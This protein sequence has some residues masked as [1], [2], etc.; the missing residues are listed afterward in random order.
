[1]LLKF[2]SSIQHSVCTT[3]L[4][5]F[6]AHRFL[7]TQLTSTKY[8]GSVNNECFN[9]DE[10]RIFNTL[11]KRGRDDGRQLL[12]NLFGCW[13]RLACPCKHAADKEKHYNAFSKTLINVQHHTG[14]T[15]YS[16]HKTPSLQVM[17]HTSI[18]VPFVSTAQPHT[19]IR[20]SA[21]SEQMGLVGC[22]PP[23]QLDKLAQ[24]SSP[25]VSSRIVYAIQ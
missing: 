18:T 23:P 2:I 4:T 10:P 15:Q 21:V 7:F 8:N 25:L 14:K 17:N 6:E 13:W 16:K 3:S 11:M 22:C 12:D 5:S 20:D 19:S 24:C 1:M 9:K